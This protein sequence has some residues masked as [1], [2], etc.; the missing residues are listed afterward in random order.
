[1]YRA[2]RVRQLLLERLDHVNGV[3]FTHQ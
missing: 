3:G 2:D 1:L